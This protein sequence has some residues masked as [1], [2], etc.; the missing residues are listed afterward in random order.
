MYRYRIFI[1]VFFL[2]LFTSALGEEEIDPQWFFSYLEKEVKGFSP[3]QLDSTKNALM[4][5]YIREYR[6]FGKE[7]ALDSLSHRTDKLIKESKKEAGVIEEPAKKQAANENNREAANKNERK[8]RKEI[9]EGEEIENLERQKEQIEQDI[10]RLRRAKKEEKSNRYTYFIVREIEKTEKKADSLTKSQLKSGANS[11]MEPITFDSIS[12]KDFLPMFPYKG[13]SYY[14]QK[15]DSAS[16][17]HFEQEYQEVLMRNMFKRRSLTQMAIYQ[18]ELI[19]FYNLGTYDDKSGDIR[20][21]RR[22]VYL[23]DLEK[24]NREP[25]FDQLSKLMKK[26]NEGP[27]SSYKKLTI[28]FSQYYVNNWYKGGTP[29]STLLSILVYN[30][31]YNK[32]DILTWDNSLNMEVGFYNTSEDTIRAFRVNNDEFNILSR[33]GYFTGIKKIYYSLSGD[34]RT[35]LFTSYDGIN[36]NDVA[37]AF[38]SPS[39]LT[40]GLGA[41]YRYNKKT[42]LQLSPLAYRLIFITDDRVDPI[43]EGIKHG[44]SASYWGYKIYGQLYWKFSRE[45]NFESKANVFCSYPHN[46]IEM[47]LELV[48]NFIIN[49]FLSSRISFKI[50]S[51]NKESIETGIQEQLSLGFNYEF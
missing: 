7:R 37:T 51:D 43:H 25:V 46:Y 2:S 38:L 12:H 15:V 35:S 28:H 50:R 26:K 44:K 22:D 11:Y 9:N 6:D 1:I 49:K 8:A 40:F 32:D 31:N 24:R 23:I 33:L 19:E 41:D 47:E 42:Y 17:T 4:S 14:P 21:N 16:K 10:E 18:P 39:T 3:E 13:I 5:S 48:G 45:I 27:W 29:N 30:K 20:N 34:F 36:S